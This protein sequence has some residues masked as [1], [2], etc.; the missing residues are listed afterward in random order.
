MK[1]FFEE[2]KY[3]FYVILHPF[4]GF[5]CIKREGKGSIRVAN[6]LLAVLLITSVLTK[7]CTAFA[8]NLTDKDSLNIFKECLLVVLPVALWCV[9][10]WSITTLMDGEGKP[11]DIYIS[12]VYSLLPLIL[13]NIPLV[14]ISHFLSLDEQSLY[15]LLQ[16]AAILWTGFL[17]FIATMTVH[18]YTIKKTV[19]MIL[20]MILGMALIVFLSLLFF[21]LIQQLTNFIYVMYKEFSLRFM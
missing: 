8:F 19:L 6:A 20:L 9:S 2:L 17:L 18:Q 10:G 1:L 15:S 3:A 21:V 4:D 16:Y 14:P 7:Q 5:W 13:F 12:C 11:R